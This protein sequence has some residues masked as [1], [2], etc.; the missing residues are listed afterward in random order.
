MFILGLILKIMHSTQKVVGG[1]ITALYA[2]ILAHT[3]IWVETGPT[4]SMVW[5]FFILGILALFIIFKSGKVK[6]R[7]QNSN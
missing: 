5:F 1:A 2:I 4:D 7:N 6:I 3:M